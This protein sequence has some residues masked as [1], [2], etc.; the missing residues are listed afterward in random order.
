MC[1]EV[2]RTVVHRGDVADIPA[3]HRAV[4][5]AWT[6]ATHGIHGQARANSDALVGVRDGDLL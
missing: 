1:V 6:V 3:C 5:R 4:H 2:P